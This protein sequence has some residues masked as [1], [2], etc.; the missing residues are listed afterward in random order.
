MPGRKFNVVDDRAGGNVLERQGIAD[1]NIGFGTGGNCGADL[2]TIG[3]DDV[4]LLAIRI[5]QQRNARRTVRIVFDR[6]DYGRNAELVALEIDDRGKPACG[7]RAMK[8]EVTR[9]VLLR[10]P[11][12]GRG[13]TS[14]FSG[15]CLVMSSRDT[16]VM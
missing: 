13:S 11:D 16:T 3:R 7:R 6:R 12:F 1:Q 9:P 10:P 4:A 2:Q 14:D 5:I 8:R 15:V